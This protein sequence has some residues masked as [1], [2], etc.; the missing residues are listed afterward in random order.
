MTKIRS[1][2]F[3]SVSLTRFAW[4]IQLIF[5][6]V[7]N[8]VVT[9][10]PTDASWIDVREECFTPGFA[11]MS[12]RQL[13]RCQLSLDCAPLKCWQFRRSPT[14]V[15]CDKVFTFMYGL[16]A[17]WSMPWVDIITPMQRSGS[18]HSWRCHTCSHSRRFSYQLYFVSQQELQSL[19]IEPLV[20]CYMAN[21]LLAREWWFFADFTNW[22]YLR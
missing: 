15:H 9:W 4:W 18:R 16:N 5:K 3:L 19:W 8:R 12:C 22:W 11:N 21:T 2:L 6:D 20:R 10:Y 7:S 1:Y 13:I 17:R 14:C